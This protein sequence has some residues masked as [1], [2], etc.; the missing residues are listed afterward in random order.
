[1]SLSDDKK[2][3]VLITQAEELQ[4]DAVGLHKE[5]KLVAEEA[6]EGIQKAL[7]EVLKKNTYPYV[8]FGV[9]SV[10]DRDCGFLGL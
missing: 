2:L 4:K 10:P 6:Q 1:M 8:G 3:Y 5:V 9:H 7:R